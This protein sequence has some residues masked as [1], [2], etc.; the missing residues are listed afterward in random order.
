[1]KIVVCVAAVPNPD[2]IRW[3]RLRQVLDLQDAEPVL[4]PV[5]RNALELAAALAKQTGSAFDAIC[6]DA[7]ASAALREAAV[8]G[9]DRMIAVED[10][11]L[12]AADAT[13]VAAALAATIAHV[14]G[15]DI[16]FCG[17]ST[18][19]FAEG[20]VPG[21][22]SALL[23]GGLVVDA[24]GVEFA[25]DR[26][27]VNA[28][29]GDGISRLV[30]SIPAVVVAAPFGIRV[31]A[32]SPVLLM[33]AA[34]K[35]QQTLTLADVGCQVPLATTGAVEGPLESD[36]GKK[37]MEVVDGDDAA[38]RARALIASLRDRQAV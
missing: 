20:A 33:K 22:L 9:A 35:A 34:K 36:R 13:G 3:D 18:A 10:D 6:A 12:E 26:L 24:L 37:A 11:A 5:D 25:D 29:D 23:R 19:S 1:M 15:A 30:T 16:V 28:L 2:K 31:R 27:S 14:G 38:T 7:G 4:N 17:A 32:V 8:F 21:Y